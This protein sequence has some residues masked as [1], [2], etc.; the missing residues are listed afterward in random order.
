MQIQESILSSFV[1]SYKILERIYAHTKES[2]I[3]NYGT[4]M[5][6]SIMQLLKNGERS[7]YA[8]KDDF[9]DMSL[10]GKW[11]STRLIVRYCL[12]RKKRK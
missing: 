3:I 10:S 2:N 12:V 5:Q 8:D 7:L 6:W 4:F 1:C 9:Q 11:Q